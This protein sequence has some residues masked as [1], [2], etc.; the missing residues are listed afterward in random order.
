MN[1]TRC[2]ALLLFSATLLA[3][4]DE[5]PA[6]PAA[7][8]TFSPQLTRRAG[9]ELWHRLSQ[10][11]ELLA[12]SA[13]TAGKRRAVTPPPAAAFVPKNF[14][15]TEVFGKMVK[16]G[17]HWT[18][19]SSDA[20][21]LRRVTLDLSGEIP[22]PETVKAFLADPSAD[23]RDRAIDL[24]LQSEGF[25]DR[26]TMWLGDLVQNVK[27]ASNNN[28]LTLARDAYW[29]YLF[30]SIAANK[31]YDQ[32]V[33][34]LIAG[35]GRQYTVGQVNHWVREMQPNGPIQDTYDNLSATT[36]SRFLA[37][38]LQ[39]LS[40]HNGLGHLE[41]SN[42]GLAKRTRYDFWRNA[43]FFAQV[44]VTIERS[45]KS[46]EAILSDNTTGAYE[47]NT[48]SGNKTPRVP[49]NGQATVDPAFILT[50]EGPRD[51]E[52]RRVAY[53]RILTAHPQFA[54]AT[55]NYL[56][57][58]LFGL[59]I[60]EPADSFDLLRQDPA[61]LP[62]GA[63]LQPTHPA[64]LT[65]LASYFSTNNYD[66]RAILKLMV[67]SNTYQLASRYDGGAWSETY[68]PYFARHYPRRLMAEMLLDAVFKATNQIP[69]ETFEDDVSLS[70][71]MMLPDTSEGGPYATMLNNFGRG[72][73]DDQPRTN[74]CSIVQALSLMNDRIITDRVKSTASGSTL[75][76]LLGSTK[77][78]GT[79]ADSLYLAV[80]SRYPS[81]SERA[82]AIEYLGSGDAA[83][84]SETLQLALINR[85]DFLFN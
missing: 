81:I 58:E 26:W 23:K 15:D 16:D 54:R 3:V 57:K 77:D 19:P 22:D 74:E 80:L 25:V 46:A 64:L 55:V 42:S 44:T 79:I 85:L 61:T 2:I 29:G 32:I 4:S 70:K 35:S 68:T 50:G 63:T 69:T 31:P 51:G 20:E 59:G 14:I 73:R 53:G 18:T 11:A 12:P 39:C 6:P 56:W 71:M 62:A 17:V 24:L 34:E 1:P 49:I 10:S 40:C 65:E 27:F 48:T 5:T 38:P 8:C 21:F 7:D 84:Q 67:S 47:L 37:L 66:L 13:S 52:P 45:P 43:A 36:G 83:Q 60:V 9:P 75:Q 30:A 82:A 28:E 72:N 41:Q 33:R 78:P 76:R